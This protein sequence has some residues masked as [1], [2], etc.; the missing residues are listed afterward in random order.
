WRV[1]GCGGRR[2]VC[3]LS[4]PDQN[5]VAEQGDPVPIG[6]RGLGCVEGVIVGLI[7]VA[8]IVFVE[9]HLDWATRKARPNTARQAAK[10]YFHVV[11][12]AR[13]SRINRDEA[14]AEV[15]TPEDRII[16]VER[17]RRDSIRREVVTDLQLAQWHGS[18]A[19]IDDLELWFDLVSS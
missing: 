14:R 11:V 13:Y 17:K 7:E 4:T 18:T 15:G 6:K 2:W 12:C 1:G 16:T 10:G 5:A 3:R 19:Q 9:A 8:P